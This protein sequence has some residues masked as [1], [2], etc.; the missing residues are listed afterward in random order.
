[1]LITM[2]WMYVHEL[3]V[4]EVLISEHYRTTCRNVI[5]LCDFGSLQFFEDRFGNNA[6]TTVFL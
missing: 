2:Q 5:E 1:M 3:L 4:Y 6:V